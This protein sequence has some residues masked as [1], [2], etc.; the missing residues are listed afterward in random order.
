MAIDIGAVAAVVTAD[1]GAATADG[2]RRI[3]FKR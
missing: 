3:L 2:G 1:P